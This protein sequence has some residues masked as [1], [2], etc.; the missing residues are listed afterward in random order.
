MQEDLSAWQLLASNFKTHG[1]SVALTQKEKDTPTNNY[2]WFHNRQ[3][4]Q[5]LSTSETTLPF[6]KE[7]CELVYIGQSSQ[8][9]PQSSASSE[10][11]IRAGNINKY[12]KHTV[13]TEIVESGRWTGTSYAWPVKMGI[14]RFR[15]SPSQ[16]ETLQD[17]RSMFFRVYAFQSA[18]TTEAELV[19]SLKE[20]LG[21]RVLNKGGAQDAQQPLL[22]MIMLFRET[23]PLVDFTI[24]LDPCYK[25]PARELYQTFEKSNFSI[26]SLQWTPNPN[27]LWQTGLNLSPVPMPPDV[28]RQ[29]IRDAMIRIVQTNFQRGSPYDHDQLCTLLSELF[30]AFQPSFPVFCQ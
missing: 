16:L 29:E 1:T 18:R 7:R 2:P 13:G 11:V 3:L 19:K 8:I 23:S 15:F 17:I 28:A 14:P 30:A 20:Q 25:V 27:N 26:H 6:L 21:W 22:Y 9:Q 4:F 5:F 10:L 24:K 12:L